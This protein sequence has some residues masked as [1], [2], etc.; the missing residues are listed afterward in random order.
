MAN[1][2]FAFG[3]FS[4]EDYAENL[5]WE[6]GVNAPTYPLGREDGSKYGGATIISKTV[7]IEGYLNAADFISWRELK[8]TMMAGLFPTPRM[9]KLYTADDRAYWAECTSVSIPEYSG[10]PQCPFSVTFLCHSPFDV[11]LSQH[12]DTWNTV[13]TQVW[14]NYA[15]SN[16][17]ACFVVNNPGFVVW[18]RIVFGNAG[19]TSPIRINLLWGN[20]VPNPSFERDYGGDGTPDSWI[21]A[22]NGGGAVWMDGANAMTGNYCASVSNSSSSNYTYIY[23]LIP[24]GTS[25]SGRAM[26]F[27][28]YM[29]KTSAGSGAG[30]VCQQVSERN[31]AGATVLDTAGTHYDW[32]ALAWYRDELTV[33]IN[34]TTRYIVWQLINHDNC[35]ASFDCAQAEMSSSATSWKDEHSKTLII[36]NGFS[37]SDKVVIDSEDRTIYRASTSQLP[38]MDGEFFPLQTGDNLLV[39]R[40]APTAIANGLFSV[41]F[42]PRYL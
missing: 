29:R 4:F 1:P 27:S 5:S 28:V 10:L 12:I 38:Y 22:G 13:Q 2:N 36:N 34:S 9:Q 20:L 19:Y 37:S 16:P 15:D 40:H 7:K 26:T 6:V 14:T 33:I 32:H 39:L 3:D 11:Q 8:D 41:V 30:Y 25:M 31:S 35:E 21:K 23:C 18:P 24:V 42:S 17:R